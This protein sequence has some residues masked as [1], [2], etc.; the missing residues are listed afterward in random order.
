MRVFWQDKCP[1]F[2]PNNEVWETHNQLS[3]QRF[4]RCRKGNVGMHI[5]EIDFFSLPPALRQHALDNA[6]AQGCAAHCPHYK[7]MVEREG[8]NAIY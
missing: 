6:M 8:A 7:E 2:G 3:M 5:K 1:V 4:I